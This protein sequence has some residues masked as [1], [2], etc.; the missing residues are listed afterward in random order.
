MQQ[1]SESELQQNLTDLVECL[2]LF[3]AGTDSLDIQ[4]ESASKHIP[5]Y[6]KIVKSHIDQLKSVLELEN[7]NHKTLETAGLA[8][9]VKQLIEMFKVL[10]DEDLNMLDNMAMVSKKWQTQVEEVATEATEETE[11]ES[12]TIM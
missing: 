11:Q 2:K 9:P 3:P 8:K 12:P 7:H 10:T 1:L 6:I 5:A 4:L